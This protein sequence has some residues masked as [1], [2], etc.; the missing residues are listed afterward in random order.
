MAEVLVIWEKGYLFSGSWGAVKTFMG[1]G[2]Q[3]NGLRD[4]GSP[5]H[6]LQNLNVKEKPLFCSILYKFLWVL[7]SPLKM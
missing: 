2:K 7:P 5:V 6:F 4:L 3:A 1:A